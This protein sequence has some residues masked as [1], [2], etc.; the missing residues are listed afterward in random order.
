MRARLERVESSGGKTLAAPRTPG[1][2][3]FAAADG[4]HA[5]PETV[6]ALANEL[7][8]LVSTFHLNAPCRKSR[9]APERMR[10]VCLALSQHLRHRVKLKLAG[11]KPAALWGKIGFKST[12]ACPAHMTGASRFPDRISSRNKNLDQDPKCI[13]C[14]KRWLPESGFYRNERRQAK[15]GLFHKPRKIVT[16]LT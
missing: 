16:S 7:A 4:G 5:G 14:T 12:K 13:G 10:R 11:S 15:P 3:H 8:R 1:S 9:P 6:P 2:N